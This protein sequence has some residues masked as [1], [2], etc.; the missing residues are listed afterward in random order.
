M[1]IWFSRYIL[2]SKFWTINSKRLL[3]QIRA[4]HIYNKLDA[5]GHGDKRVSLLS[6]HLYS[7]LHTY[8]LYH[9][10]PPAEARPSRRIRF[11]NKS[12]GDLRHSSLCPSTLVTSAAYLR[13][14]LCWQ[15]HLL[16]Q[17]LCP[18]KNDVKTRHFS[19]QWLKI[20]L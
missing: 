5:K 8:W 6:E 14:V 15:G 19:G 4:C 1:G 9:M 17:L 18:L 20:L 10:L 3:S 16:Y 12:Y 11:N 13:S 7:L 2:C